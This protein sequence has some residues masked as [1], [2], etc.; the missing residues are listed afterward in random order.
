MKLR[1]TTLTVLMLLVLL[2]ILR[3][4]SV[5]LEE[6]SREQCAADTLKPLFA[7]VG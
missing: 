5:P 7:L 4:F 3:L 6:V 2:L 1:V